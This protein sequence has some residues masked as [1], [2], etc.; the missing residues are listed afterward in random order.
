MEER[1]RR[2]MTAALDGDKASYRTLL[3]DLSARLRNYFLR[4][5]GRDR[6]ADAEDLVQETLMAIHARRSTYDRDRPFT[7][8][9]HAVARYKLMDHFRQNRS[10]HSV[11]IDDVEDFLAEDTSGA[12]EASLDVGRLLDAIPPKRSDLI[13]RVRIEGQSVAEAATGTGLSE[14]AV[15][16]G[17]HRGVKAMSRRVL[18]ESDDGGA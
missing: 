3:G 7:P 11:P 9:L 8:W 10:R 5:L 2:L 12:L 17:V 14:A 1:L 13:R 6:A 18:G 16:I 4:R 15:K